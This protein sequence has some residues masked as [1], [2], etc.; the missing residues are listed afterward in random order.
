MKAFSRRLSAERASVSDDD[1]RPHEEGERQ[2]GSRA[3]PSQSAAGDP[4][5]VDRQA[6]REEDRDLRQARQSP[7]KRS[8]SPA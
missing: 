4:A 8:I 5:E 2:R 7:V 1:E 3:P 6:E